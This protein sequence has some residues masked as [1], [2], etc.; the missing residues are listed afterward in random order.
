MNHTFRLTNTPSGQLFESLR[1]V[2]VQV[3]KCNEGPVHLGGILHSVY[4]KKPFVLYNYLGTHL[5]SKK[6]DNNNYM[7]HFPSGA[8]ITP[9]MGVALYP[10]DQAVNVEFDVHYEACI[11]DFEIPS[12]ILLRGPNGI[13][14]F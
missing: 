3:D 12:N 10:L 4:S 11:L 6:I 13:T 2:V 8:P 5:T 7:I 9:E 1:Q 14:N